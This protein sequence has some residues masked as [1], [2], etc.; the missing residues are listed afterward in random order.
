MPL[1]NI[2]LGAFLLTCQTELPVAFCLV[3]KRREEFER[4][5]EDVLRR[6]STIQAG[7]HPLTP[8]E[9]MEV[10]SYR[11]AQSHGKY[12][13]KALAWVENEEEA[14]SVKARFDPAEWDHASFVLMPVSQIPY[15]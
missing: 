3:G 4:P 7:P 6:A 12:V 13:Q 15:G 11:Y 2:Q 14:E 9:L 10:Q 1:Y 5:N 8:E